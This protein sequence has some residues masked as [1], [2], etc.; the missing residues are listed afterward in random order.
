MIQYIKNLKDQLIQNNN[1]SIQL[2]HIKQLH[3]YHLYSISIYLIVRQNYMPKNKTNFSS[4]RSFFR[5]LATTFRFSLGVRENLFL[6]V[7]LF[8]SSRALFLASSSTA[9]SELIILGMMSWVEDRV[10]L[11]EQKVVQ[12]HT[13]KDDPVDNLKISEGHR[14]KENMPPSLQSSEEGIYYHP[15][16]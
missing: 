14:I 3:E 6:F 12:Q 4:E 7:S 13:R 1:S 16:F 2:F 15:G 9:I 8:I 5:T 10:I 11:G